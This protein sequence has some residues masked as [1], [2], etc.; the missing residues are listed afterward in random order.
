MPSLSNEEL[1]EK[2]SALATEIRRLLPDFVDSCRTNEDIV[3]IHQDS[4]AADYQQ[5]E[6]VLLGKAIKFAGLYGKELRIIG[7]NRETLKGSRKPE[8]IH[9]G[10]TARERSSS[11]WVGGVQDS[12]PTSNK[13]NSFIDRSS[14]HQAPPA[15]SGP[16]IPFCK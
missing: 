12:A 9:D 7:T 11:G 2:E 15:V 8:L 16:R 13:R 1:R 5:D 3:I 14:H 10:M 6:F 4:F